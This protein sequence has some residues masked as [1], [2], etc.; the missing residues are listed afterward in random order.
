VLLVPLFL[1]LLS[2]FLRVFR[3]FVL[4][5]LHV[6][7]SPL[8]GFLCL[9]PRLRLRFL[10]HLLRRGLRGSGLGLGSTRN[11]KRQTEKDERDISRNLHRFSMRQMKA[12]DLAN[13]LKTS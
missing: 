13:G 7:L 1:R 2:G 10:R 6:L 3:S 11:G 5:L 8:L 4:G 12:L 9:L